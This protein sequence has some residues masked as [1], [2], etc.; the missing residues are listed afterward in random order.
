MSFGFDV[1]PLRASSSSELTLFSALRGRS[2]P[3]S[4]LD[5]TR[6]S[7]SLGSR[8][9]LREANA[10]ERP[11][12]VRGKEVSIGDAGMAGRR[13]ARAAPQRHLP[14]HEL[15]VVLADGTPGGLEA[16]V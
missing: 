3:A 15:A 4:L 5:G 16:G 9:V 6:I 2:G 7:R 14:A 8:D 10:R 1:S 11:A 13:D 12:A